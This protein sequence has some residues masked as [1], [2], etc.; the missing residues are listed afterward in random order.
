VAVIGDST[1]LLTG[2]LPL[3]QRAFAAGRQLSTP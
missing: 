2:L 3:N 1:F